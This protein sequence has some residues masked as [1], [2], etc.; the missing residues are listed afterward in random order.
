MADKSPSNILTVSVQTAHGLCTA[1]PKCV[2]KDA[3]DG[4]HWPN[5]N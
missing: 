4:P 1:D 5:S 2:R 3:H